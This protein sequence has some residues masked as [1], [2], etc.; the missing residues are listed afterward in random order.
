MCFERRDESIYLFSIHLCRLLITLTLHRSFRCFRYS[1]LKFLTYK[2]FCKYVI[3]S[4]KMLQHFVGR[5]WEWWNPQSNNSITFSL[6]WCFCIIQ[7]KQQCCGMLCDYVIQLFIIWSNWVISL[8]NFVEIILCVLQ[9]KL[10]IFHLL[11]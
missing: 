4:I 6:N 3:Y 1:T 11:F 8:E 7:S 9:W 2:R 5:D 10:E